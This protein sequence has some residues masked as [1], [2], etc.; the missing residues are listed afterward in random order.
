MTYI[1]RLRGN[2][3]FYSPASIINNIVCF[4]SASNRRGAISNL[5]Q[6]KNL[7]WKPTKVRL[8]I[9]EDKNVR[10][11][12]CILFITNKYLP[13]TYVML[14]NKLIRWPIIRT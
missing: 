8:I 7:Y 11:I 4:F 14:N 1:A 5:M 10:N 2:T 13:K 6:K 12:F 3:Y 9:Y